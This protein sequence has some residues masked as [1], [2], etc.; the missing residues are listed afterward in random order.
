M[1]NIFLILTI[2]SLTACVTYGK[3]FDAEKAANFKIGKTTYR[4]VVQELGEPTVVTDGAMGDGTKSITYQ[5]SETD[6]KTYIPV[7]GAYLGSSQS[8]F[9]I[10]Y[11]NNKN[12]LSSKLIQASK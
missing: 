12:I 1:K 4:E 6:A 8:K 5:Y 7:V 11:F 9:A 10:F 3:K 2:L